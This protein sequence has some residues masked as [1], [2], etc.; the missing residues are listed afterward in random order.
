LIWPT[1]RQII[2]LHWIFRVRKNGVFFWE[3]GGRVLAL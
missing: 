3:I 2:T 1:F